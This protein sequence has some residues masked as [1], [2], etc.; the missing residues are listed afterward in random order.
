MV[1]LLVGS[2][3]FSLVFR[4]L[5]GDIWIEDL[6]T[7]LPGGRVGLLIVANLVVF[8]LGFFIDFFEI[9]F[10]VLPL[11]APAARALGTGL[12]VFQF[13][14]AAL[15][16]AKVGGQWYVAGADEIATAALDAAADCFCAWARRCWAQYCLRGPWSVAKQCS[17][18]QSPWQSLAGTSHTRQ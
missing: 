1:W 13:A 10:I 5:Y 12:L 4:G 6:L 15:R 18:F 9:A 3:A 14:D 7:N 2:T 16:D 8:I 17:L 11:L